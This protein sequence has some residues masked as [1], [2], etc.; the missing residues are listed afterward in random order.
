MSY[1]K[2]SKNWEI[3]SWSRAGVSSTTLLRNVNTKRVIMFDCGGIGMPDMISADVVLVTHTHLDHCTGLFSH[4]RSRFSINKESANKYIVPEK[5][6]GYI[7]QLKNIY[8]QMDSGHYAPGLISDTKRS[9]KM[10]IVAAKTG[11]IID[12]GKG[13]YVECF[14]TDHVVESY[15]YLIFRNEKRIKEE[16]KNL[17]KEEKAALG[18]SSKVELTENVKVIELAYTGDTTING[19]DLRMFQ[20]EV[21]ITECTF[22]NGV[23]SQKAKDYKHMLL[24]DLAKYIEE[25][26]IVLDDNHKLVLIHFSMRY[27]PK[28]IYNSVKKIDVLKN[29]ICTLKCFNHMEGITDKEDVI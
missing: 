5:S 12:I 4:A 24:S 11:A 29:T 15:G 2:I 17:T 28:H 19:F 20:A 13:L 23:E 22:I 6:V 3:A 1:K 16:Y 8:E 9:M 10:D 18:S 27:S 25:N 7:M 26:G 21:C 14:K